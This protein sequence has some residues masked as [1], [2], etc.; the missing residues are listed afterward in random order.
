MT[1]KPNSEGWSKKP[2]LVLGMKAS[3]SGSS[4]SLTTLILAAM[5]MALRHGY[6]NPCDGA[7][8]VKMYDGPGIEHPKGGDVAKKTLAAVGA[9]MFSQ[10]FESCV[11]CNGTGPEGK[12][13]SPF[14]GGFA[15]QFVVTGRI[16]IAVLGRIKTVEIWGRIWRVGRVSVKTGEAGAGSSDLTALAVSA[17]FDSCSTVVVEQSQRSPVA[18]PKNS[19]GGLTRQSAS[20]LLKLRSQ[21]KQCARLFRGLT[22]ARSCYWPNCDRSFGRIKTV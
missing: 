3:V 14:H 22:V 4:N 11:Y 9:T 13:F 7:S 20:I 19:F 2:S 10:D 5:V 12:R 21:Q 1:G 6:P 17:V 8:S 15:T 16:L 18:N